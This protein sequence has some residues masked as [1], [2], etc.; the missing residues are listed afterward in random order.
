[1]TFWYDEEENTLEGNRLGEFI[2]V[3][4][5]HVTI[6]VD[7]IMTEGVGLGKLREMRRQIE[8]AIEANEDGDNGGDN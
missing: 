1:M 3:D 4:G 6:D 8:K 5:E 2:E 7:G